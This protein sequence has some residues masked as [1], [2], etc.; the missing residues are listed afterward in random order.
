MIYKSKNKLFGNLEE[1]VQ[2]LVDYHKVNQGL[3]SWGIRVIDQVKTVAE[4]YEIDTTNLQYGDAVAVG[5]QAPFFFY[6][7]TRA[8]I[9]GGEAYWLPFGEINTIGPEGPKGDKGDKG[10]KGEATKIHVRPMPSSAINANEFPVGDFVLITLGNESGYIYQVVQNNQGQNTLE[11]N[12]SIRGPQGLQ[13]IQGIQ[14][15][16]GP[17][18]E[19]GEKGDT[20]DVG[21]FINIYGILATADQLPLPS[22][23]NNLTAAYLVG[24][25][26]PYTLYVQVGS[27]SDEATWNDVGPFNAATAVSVNGQY[28]NIWDA[29][30]KVD[31]V[32][33]AGN[34]RLYKINSDGTQAT[35]GIT[36]APVAGNNQWTVPMY[37]PQDYVENQN[38]SWI[39]KLPTGGTLYT[40]EPKY[41][42]QVANKKYVDS[43]VAKF[44]GD[45]GN[46][47]RVY[48][49]TNTGV[50][51]TF[52]AVYPPTGGPAIPLFDGNKCISTDTPVSDS[53]CANKKYVDD[54][55][56][57]SYAIYNGQTLDNKTISV[58]FN[59]KNI[60]V[61][62]GIAS[63][64]N[65]NNIK[66]ALNG[67]KVMCTGYCE[68]DSQ[69]I[70]Q[71]GSDGTS[72]NLYN[73]QGQLKYV[74]TG[75]SQ[76]LAVDNKSTIN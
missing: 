6:I 74:L 9:E 45:T 60:E 1:T 29:D 62:V 46:T 53:N 61:E 76:G 55:T 75:G 50:E 34:S 69:H 3:A 42:G 21:G 35:V 7:W 23:L 72:I 10:D 24:T 2:Y 19:K 39:N 4:V 17:Q 25:Q 44:T 26:E 22:S 18:G 13:G 63:N 66:S 47:N 64:T 15:I 31:K 70:F 37:F 28:Q 5:T 65:L 36:D 41:D 27:T 20:G 67:K 33:T 56:I 12:G 16:Q 54:K 57:Y 49:I 73:A 40:I 32:S 68:E 38:S 51:T 30:T 58:V 52:K 71:I 11:L 8:S 14:G 59:Y 48:G 43:K